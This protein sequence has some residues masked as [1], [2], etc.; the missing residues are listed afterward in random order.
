[1]VFLVPSSALLEIS[2]APVFR[3]RE[4]AVGREVKATY[5]IDLF[6]AGGAG[7]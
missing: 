4:P 6:L 1:V 7:V 2:R 3:V 5:A